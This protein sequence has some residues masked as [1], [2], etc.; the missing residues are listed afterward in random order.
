MIL[1][2]EDEVL[3]NWT[4]SDELRHEGFDVISAYSAD[5]AIDIL[6]IRADVHVVFTDIDMPGSIDGLRLAAAIR[7]R[8]PPVRVIV[9]SGKEL[10][11]ALPDRVSFVPKPYTT[12][13]VLR[14]MSAGR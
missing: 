12:I 8:W 4:T 3:I 10:P 7:D 14:A 2:V 5:E 9:T 11:S 13:A 1:V 6:E